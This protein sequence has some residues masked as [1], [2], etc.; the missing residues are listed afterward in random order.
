MDNTAVSVGQSVTKGQMV[1]ELGG[2]GGSWPEHAHI[3]LQV[4]GFGLP[5]YVVADVVDPHP[6]ITAVPPPSQTIDL[7]RFFVAHP[8]CWRVVRHPGGNQED[9]QDMSLPGGFW[10]RRKNQQGEWW[11]QDSQF[12]YLVH[13]TSP[14]P[15]SQGV[16]RLYTLTKNGIPGAPKN[17]L[18]MALGGAWQ[19]SGSH[20][21]QFKAK[22][23]CALLPENSGNAQN[24]AVLTRHETNYTFNTYGQGLVFDEVIWIQT[25]QETQIYGRHNGQSAGWLGWSAPW[26]QSEPVEIYWDRGRMTQEP[27]RICPF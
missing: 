14:A 12:Y 9:I 17:P 6:Y 23:N 7:T 1:G 18:Q 13:D 21:V 24:T 25:G 4:P 8:D 10:V 19:E 27:N 22:N 3:N 16:E 26:G 20:H 15:G 2:T 11:K 5:G